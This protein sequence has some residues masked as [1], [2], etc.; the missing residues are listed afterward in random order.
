[1]FNFFLL[2]LLLLFACLQPA[3]VENSIAAVFGLTGLPLPPR[4]AAPKPL[5]RVPLIKP[6]DL[7]TGE[8]SVSFL[9]VSLSSFS[10]GRRKKKADTLL[11]S[12]PCPLFLSS[13]ISCLLFTAYGVAG[14]T[15]SG[16]IK[17]RQAVAEFQGQLMSD[18]DLV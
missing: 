11:V 5:G 16:S 18:K 1:M 6:S 13:L 9:L 17:N 14:V 2:L 10:V 12:T 7:I 4:A 3:A 15:P 8:I